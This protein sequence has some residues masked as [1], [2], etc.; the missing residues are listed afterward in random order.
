[1]NNAKWLRWGRKRKKRCKLIRVEENGGKSGG[2]AASAADQAAV[3]GAHD[4]QDTRRITPTP[5]LVLVLVQ[6]QVQ[7]KSAL[8]VSTNYSSVA[9]PQ[10]CA[11]PSAILIHVATTIDCFLI[12]HPPFND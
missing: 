11:S 3:L 9:A 1:M 10:S 4:V 8:R 6:V 5:R 2:F 7:G 12:T